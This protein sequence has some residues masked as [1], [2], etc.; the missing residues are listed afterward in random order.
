MQ[1]YIKLMTE[2]L[3][4]DVIKNKSCK[5]PMQN[6]ITNME[7]CTKDEGKLPMSAT[8]MVCWLSATGHANSQVYH[9]LAS[10]RVA[11]L[12]KG[13]LKAGMCIACFFA[14]NK[15]PCLFQL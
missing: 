8:S 13:A 3:G 9:S 5:L 12:F 2:K 14:D 10:Q 6:D 4:I 15:E 1:S 11:A 7:L